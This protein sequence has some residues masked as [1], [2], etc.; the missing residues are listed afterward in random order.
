MGMLRYFLNS[1]I[2]D[3]L[4]YENVLNAGTGLE[5]QVILFHSLL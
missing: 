1:L 5:C 3:D 2:Y 4:D